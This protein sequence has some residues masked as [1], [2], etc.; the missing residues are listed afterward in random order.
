MKRLA[1]TTVKNFPELKDVCET[2]TTKAESST[3]RSVPTPGAEFYGGRM[4]FGGNSIWEFAAVIGE[5]FEAS[6]VERDTLC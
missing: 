4:S 3:G 6:K 5:T 1:Q 2:S